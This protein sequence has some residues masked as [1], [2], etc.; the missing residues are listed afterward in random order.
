MTTPRGLPML[1]LWQPWASAM[2]T[3]RRPNLST[4]VMLKR[5]ETRSWPAPPALIGERWGV[6]ST[7]T[8]EGLGEMSE[9]QERQLRNSLPIDP[10]IGW[11]TSGDADVSALDEWLPRGRVLGSGVLEACV[12]IIGAEPDVT[13]FDAGGYAWVHPDHPTIVRVVRY[14]GIDRWAG[15]SDAVYPESEWGNYSTTGKPRYAW[16]F[17][18]LAPTTERCPW[19]WG[20]GEDG[21]GPWHFRTPFAE[22]VPCRVC[23]EGHEHDDL[24]AVLRSCPP[25]PARGGQRVWYWTPPKLET[26]A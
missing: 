16:V 12:P 22:E 8:A 26:A 19:C 11:L 13:P 15:Q 20:R 23:T 17:D 7:L 6:H 21:F 4:P 9:E 5:I 25:I 2:V 1:S 18:E 24:N 10:D 14:K 3:Y